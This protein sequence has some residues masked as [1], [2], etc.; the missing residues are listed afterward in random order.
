ML[1]PRPSRPASSILVLACVLGPLVSPSRLARAHQAE[2]ADAP[3][4][5][6]PGGASGDAETGAV[7]PS[8]ADGALDP[9]FDPEPLADSDRPPPSMWPNVVR[10]EAPRER[11]PD[12]AKL[13]AAEKAMRK[14]FA[15]DFA[16][17]TP[18][19]RKALAAKLMDAAADEPNVAVRY[20]LLREA[21]KAAAEVGDTAGLMRAIDEAA[22]T[23]DVD[24]LAEQLEAIRKVPVPGRDRAAA[25]AL[26]VTCMRLAGQAMR[27]R[28]HAEGA[29][30]VAGSAEA[31]AAKAGDP[32]LLAAARARAGLA[33]AYAKSVRTAEETRKHLADVPDD[34]AARD[35][36]ARL[37]C[38]SQEDWEVGLALLAES[39]E[40][41]VKAVA[42]RDLAGHAEPAGRAKI[43]DA[44][45]DL[46][47]KETLT[48]A[49]AAQR[50][51][52]AAW[53][54]LALPGL[55]G[56]AKTPVEKR[57]RQVA[58]EGG[59]PYGA[60]DAT[61]PHWKQALTFSGDGHVKT[62]DGHGLWTWDGSELVITFDNFPPETPAV[63]DGKGGFLADNG[64]SMQPKS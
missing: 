51:R 35:A 26:T 33:R 60:Y 47:A 8:A 62:A 14:A 18:D 6:E 45:W 61:H 25:R 16:K 59:A 28:G 9:A 29:A 55:Q 17:R 50:R 36:L 20:V 4:T 52:A 27:R 49:R 11:V 10:P 43:G 48:S 54:V 13:A 63:P 64:F 37:L 58:L 3:A 46:A 53:Y 2:P 22:V 30:R 42:K 56:L 31:A 7:P 19:A 32:K 39:D 12:A 34:K 15:G 57:L 24:A 41:T 44:W 38:F 5:A 1:K 21:R 23:F 40:P